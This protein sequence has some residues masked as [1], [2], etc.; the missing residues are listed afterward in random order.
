METLTKA[1]AEEKGIPE[2]EVFMPGMCTEGYMNHCH[3]DAN[4]GASHH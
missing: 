2:S 3:D 4:S 1:F